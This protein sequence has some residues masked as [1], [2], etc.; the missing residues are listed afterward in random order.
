LKV[1]NKKDYQMKMRRTYGI[2]PLRRVS[3]LLV[4]V[5]LLCSVAVP[6][7][8]GR[9]AEAVAF[10]TRSLSLS[11]NT[12]AG[13][14]AT[15]SYSF[16][17]VV[18]TGGTTGLR[19]VEVNFCTSPLF[20]ACTAPTGMSVSSAGVGTTSPA[21]GATPSSSDSGT[22]N[23]AL[24][25]SGTSRQVRFQ[26]GSDQTLSL[27]ATVT[28]ILT[29]IQNPTTAGT[30]YA[31]IGFFGNGDTTYTTV[32]DSGVVAQAVQA[33]QTVSFKV[34]E[35]LSFCVGAMPNATVAYTGF[36]A[37]SLTNNCAQS[38]GTNIAMGIAPDSTTSCVTPVSVRTGTC[39]DTS[40]TNDNNYAYAMLQTNA[41][42]G[43]TIGYRPNSSTSYTQGTLQ[44]AG[45]TG[46]TFTSR[47]DQCI[48]P[49]NED[50]SIAVGSV[51]PWLSSSTAEQFGMVV[52]AINST[53]RGTSVL[54]NNPGAVS[55]VNRYIGSGNLS[56]GTA[57]TTGGASAQ[58]CWNWHRT[59]TA[60]LASAPSPVDNEAIQIFFATKA[61][62][63][64]PSGQYDVN[65]DYYTVPTY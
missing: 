18:P 44:R 56:G 43:S 12:N 53:G 34:Q 48:N 42:N 55:A 5:A 47:T 3:N 10:T 46:C 19:S 6:M 64:T 33:T 23:S 37:A 15:T 8:M 14:T 7:L 39:D 24:A 61:A 22:P 21:G 20:G 32:T 25:S 30:F 26:W 60:T 54:T 31:R 63:T 36:G 52:P 2:A 17:V 28:F 62:I 50:A 58:D 38:A 11:N 13:S 40:T 16:S 29:N 59:G 41:G 65:I 27:P 51:A 57:C 4:A 49:V 9:S 35:T 1:K 45:A